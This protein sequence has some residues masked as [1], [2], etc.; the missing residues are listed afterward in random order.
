M[1]QMLWL[2]PAL[3]LLGAVIN[4]LIGKRLPRA[5]SSW[6]AVLFMVAAFAAAAIAVLNL[7]TLP[8]DGRLIHETLYQWI[9][10]GIGSHAFAVN[11]A[12][13]LDPLSAVMI[14]VITGVGTLIHIYAVGYME[15]EKDY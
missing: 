6:L 11:V 1:T 7:A 15:H 12:F 13:W 10:V 14:L 2:I 4:G 5:V 3:P 8:A 9:G